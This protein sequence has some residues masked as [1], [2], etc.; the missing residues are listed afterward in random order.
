LYTTGAFLFLAVHGQ[1]RRQSTRIFKPGRC[2]AVDHRTGHLLFRNWTPA[3]QEAFQEMKAENEVRDEKIE[4]LDG[5]LE[6]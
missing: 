4:A 1:G 3:L 5:T 2:L 6:T